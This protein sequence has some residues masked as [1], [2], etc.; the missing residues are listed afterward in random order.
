MRPLPL[1]RINGT[2]APFERHEKGEDIRVWGKAGGDERG[3]GRRIWEER[4]DEEAVG[5]LL[6]G[7]GGDR[8]KGRKFDVLRTVTRRREGGGGGGGVAWIHNFLEEFF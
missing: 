8:V 2:E 6:E 1:L 7:G 5:T 4:G 3:E